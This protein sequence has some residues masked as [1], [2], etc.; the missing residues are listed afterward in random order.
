MTAFAHW[1]TQHV[2]LVALFI[3]CVLMLIG[4]VL[5]VREQYKADKTLQE[6]LDYSNNYFMRDY[7]LLRGRWQK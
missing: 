6:P 1:Y 3:G 4:F 2:G 5:F 7:Q